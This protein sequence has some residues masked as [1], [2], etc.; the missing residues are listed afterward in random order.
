MRS[1]TSVASDSIVESATPILIRASYTR[2]LNKLL[3]EPFIGT[4]ST[5]SFLSSPS[6]RNHTGVEKFFFVFL[7]ATIISTSP[8]LFSLLRK[9]SRVEEYS[10]N[11]AQALYCSSL[12]F[13]IQLTIF[14][15]SSSS[16]AMCVKAVVSLAPCQC[17][18]PAGT[19]TTSPG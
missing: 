1:L 17:F 6:K 8:D 15:S 7:P 5:I 19:Q 16:I 14:L 11:A 12:T 9:F 2:F 4:S 3:S 13:S 18:S 10:R